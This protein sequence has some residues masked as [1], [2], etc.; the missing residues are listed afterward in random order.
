MPKE[1][2][3]FDHLRDI[4]DDLIQGV[5]ID[6]DN[7]QY[8]LEV[9]IKEKIALNYSARDLEAATEQYAD[10]AVDGTLKKIWGILST[11]ENEQIN[12]LKLRI[13]KNLM[14]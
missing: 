9:D 7:V 11:Y 13:K 10:F 14:K 1:L 8:K 3:I 5:K 6:I 4:I 2:I 12:S